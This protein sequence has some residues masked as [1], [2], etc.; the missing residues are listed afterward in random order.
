MKPTCAGPD[1]G[2]HNMKQNLFGGRRIA[3]GSKPFRCP[4]AESIRCRAIALG[5]KLAALIFDFDGVIADSEALANTVLAEFVTE[6]G[7]PT[8]LEDSLEHYSGRRWD[9][10]IAAIER[11]VAKPLPATF[12]DDLRLAILA[13]FRTDLREVSGASQFI[14]KFSEVPR[15]IASSSSID[16][17]QLCLS[18]LDLADRFGRNVFSA[19]MVPRGKPHPDI[20]LFAADKLG[21]SP[22]SCLV[23]EDS[24]SGIR[25]A[26]AAG[27]TAVGLCAASHIRGGHQLKLRDAGA[28][29]LAN[30]WD[31]VERI[32]VRF[33]DEAARHPPA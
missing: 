28:V 7:H 21:V 26:V 15:C 3:S 1:R 6:L 11:A 29:H 5:L 27:M 4:I 8:N 19:D 13:R 18:V 22:R 33:F 2:R 32:A 10:A 9:D 25:A 31:D 23:I 12:S 17:L 30:S 24:A 14:R 16:R 20:F